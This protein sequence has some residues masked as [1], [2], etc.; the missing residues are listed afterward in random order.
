[1]FL[2]TSFS[3]LGLHL[4]ALGFL[5]TI[6]I[7]FGTRVTYGHS[8]QVPQASGLVLY[9]FY[10]TQLVVLSRFLYSLN[11]GFSWSFEFLFDISITAWLILFI[12]WAYKFIPTLIK[13]YVD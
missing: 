2:E 12:L 13:G 1:M 8:G 3:F 5:T 9:L 6:L 7:G 11:L 4:V 10:F